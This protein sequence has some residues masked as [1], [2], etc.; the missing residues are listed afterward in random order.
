MVRDP[1]CG[2]EVD[3]DRSNWVAE[4][5]SEDH[6]FCSEDCQRAFMEDPAK[7]AEIRPMGR[8]HAGHGGHVGGCC[9]VGMGRGWLSYVHL[10]IIILFILLLLFR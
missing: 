9:G 4:Y 6:Y 5:D 7:Y 2:M 3:P 10:A 8:S 1:V